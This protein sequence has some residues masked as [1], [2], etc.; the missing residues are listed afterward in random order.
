MDPPTMQPTSEFL[1]WPKG[2]WMVYCSHNSFSS[3]FLSSLESFWK[4][5]NNK[6]SQLKHRKHSNTRQDLPW[7]SLYTAF[8]VFQCGTR[9]IKQFR[10]AILFFLACDFCR[11]CVVIQFFHLRHNGQ[12]LPTSKDFY[13]GSYPLHYFLILILEKASIS[14]FNV[15]C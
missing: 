12:W 4:K 2:R 9:T 13:T 10:Y 8:F 15:E 11:F 5:V 6:L 14:L 3:L 7:N 1:F